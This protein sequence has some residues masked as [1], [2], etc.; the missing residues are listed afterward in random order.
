MARRTLLWFVLFAFLFALWLRVQAWVDRDRAQSL[1]LEQAAYRQIRHLI[2]ERYVDDVDDR[3]LFFGALEGMAA[4]LDRHTAFWTPEHYELEKSSTSGHFGG[5]GIE[6]SMDEEEGLTIVTPMQDTPAFRA[7]LLPDDRIRKIDGQATQGM[8]LNEASR[9]LRGPPESK[10]VL[11]VA[12]A[13]QEAPFDVEVLREVIKVRSVQ[14]TAVLAAPRSVSARI[15]AEAPKLG[16]VQVAAFQEET[17]A[18]LD[19]AMGELERQGIRG[20]I[21]DLRQ[22][23]GG[24]LTSAVDVCDLFLTEGT[25]VS[26][27]ARADREGADEGPEVFSAHGDGTHPTYPL[28]VLIDSQSASASEIV[29]GCLKDSGRAV[30]VGEKS[31]GKGS[32]QTIIPVT[33]GGLGEAALKLTTGKYYTPSGVCIDGTGIL[34]DFE[35]KFE[36]EQLRGLLLAR[37]QRRLA[38]NDPRRNGSQAAPVPPPN[39]EGKPDKEKEEAEKF[40]DTQLEKAVE[41]LIRQLGK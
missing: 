29:A 10:V 30:L 36:S 37:R 22:N 33:L 4:S 39:P 12:R 20:L 19:R 38:L 24:L 15:P 8:D 17:A 26:T 13:G 41:V 3:K 18:D 34:P 2:D 14:E 5:L 28:V 1:A 31:Y 25:I 40:N 23:R 32:V 6:I 21:L 11:T 27:R 35:V 7:G 9:L 16:Y